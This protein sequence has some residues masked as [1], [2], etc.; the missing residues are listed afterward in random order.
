MNGQRSETSRTGEV[1]TGYDR[2]HGACGQASPYQHLPW[3]DPNGAS[4]ASTKD[5]ACWW[6]ACWTVEAYPTEIPHA[7]RDTTT[8]PHLIIRGSHV[9][10]HDVWKSGPHLQLSLRE[11]DSLSGG[12]MW[13]HMW[14][15][16]HVQA[17]QPPAS[18][19]V[20]VD[21][22]CRRVGSTEWSSEKAGLKW[23]RSRV[24]TYQ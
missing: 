16:W 21:E 20:V 22:V 12:R 10:P 13:A 24:W 23:R 19:D 11:R 8:A 7:L 15:E 3:T 4:A 5:L 2:G 1:Q 18:L 6:P 9:Q 14:A 17:E